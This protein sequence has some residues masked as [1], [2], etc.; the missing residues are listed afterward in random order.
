MV[1]LEILATLNEKTKYPCTE[2]L[3][4]IK[5]KLQIDVYHALNHKY[6]NET[7]KMVT[8]PERFIDIFAPSFAKIYCNKY[9]DNYLTCTAKENYI[10]T[11]S[12]TDLIIEELI[13]QTLSNEKLFII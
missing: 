8:N 12:Q 13:I 7:S 1:S 6:K 9:C 3:I 2:K 10:K 4:E 11:N 5:L